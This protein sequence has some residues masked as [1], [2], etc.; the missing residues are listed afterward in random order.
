MAQPYDM[1]VIELRGVERSLGEGEN[2]NLV[3]KGLNLK[4]GRGEFCAIVGPSGSGKSTLMYLLGA[5]DRPTD[6]AVLIDGD[7]TARLGELALADLR[8]RKLGFIFQFHY[9]LPEFSALENVMMPMFK[10]GTPRDEA[11]ERAR[12]LLT[13]LGL[14]DKTHRVPGK[15]SG[16]E[17]QRVAIARALANQPLCVLGDEPTGNLDTHNADHVF[18]AFEKLVKEHNQTIVVVT[19]DL[20]M[21]ARTRRIIRIVDGLIVDDGPTED[22][23][24]RM[25]SQEALSVRSHE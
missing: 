5:L 19:H 9:L 12:A 17:Q 16:G 22:V 6:G 13:D 23:L 20:D 24:Y 7:D 21:A 11:A 18:A 1:P 2:R 3:L 14:G 4:I 25:K 8:N 10:L 15:L